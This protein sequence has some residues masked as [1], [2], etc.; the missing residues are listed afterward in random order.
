M[1]G[2]ASMGLLTTVAALG[3]AS[4]AQADGGVALARGETL[5]Q[6]SE[7][8]TEIVPIGSVETSCSIS[9][10]GET[11]AKAQTALARERAKVTAQLSA[12]GA[13]SD[14]VRFGAVD[15]TSYSYA[16]D[17]D[18]END[19]AAAAVRA[20]AEAAAAAAAD[21]PVQLKTGK[22]ATQQV[23]IK[24]ASFRDFDKVVGS[25][26]SSKCDRATPI[27]SAANESAVIQHAQ[28]AAMANARKRADMLATGM[29][30]KVVSLRRVQ[31]QDK[32]SAPNWAEFI[33]MMMMTEG[34]DSGHLKKLADA[35]EQNKVP[36]T[37]RL[38][39]EF[40]LAPK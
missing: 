40:V 9:G 11:E 37:V 34:R 5:L 31:E 32:S 19:A 12:V 15:V 23:A 27:I 20:A 26:E 38:N 39:V 33:T 18:V 24:L 13:K 1:K 14:A 17:Y 16:G 22:T 25:M 21:E 36:V 2:H 35:Y 7:I 10:R 29:N 8:V 30:M 6:L 3:M 4:T 28:L